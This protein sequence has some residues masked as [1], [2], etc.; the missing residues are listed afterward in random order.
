VPLISLHRVDPAYT[1]LLSH[2]VLNF[3]DV[4]GVHLHHKHYLVIE[5]TF[6]F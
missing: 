1:G 2:A 5:E 3:L 4:R 6:A